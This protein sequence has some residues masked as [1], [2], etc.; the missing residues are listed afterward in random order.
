MNHSEVS[1]E[2]NESTLYTTETR[3]HHGILTTS[4]LSLP[5]HHTLLEGQ[6]STS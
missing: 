2:Y 5:S 6:R 1:E 3:L 4:Q